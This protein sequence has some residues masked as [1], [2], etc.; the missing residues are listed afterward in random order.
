MPAAQ[1]PTL[2]L[3]VTATAITAVAIAAM[4][5]SDGPRRPLTFAGAVLLPGVE[6]SAASP[7]PDS[8]A[9]LVRPSAS[10]TRARTPAAPPAATPS[11]VA[12]SAGYSATMPV[13][14]PV[15]N[16]SS[17]A[18]PTAAPSSPQAGTPA[19]QPPRYAPATPTRPSGHPAKPNTGSSEA[20]LAQALF[21]A[22]N[23]ARQQAGLAPLSWSASLQRSAAGHN[24][25]MAQAGTLAFRVGD[26]P[27]LGVRQANQGVL[28]DYAAENIASTGTASLAA[29]LAAQ[30]LMLAEQPPN[31]SRRRNLLSTAVNAVGIDVLLDPAHDRMWIT[32]DFAHLSG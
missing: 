22:L 11:P 28:G 2:W 20:P 31:D 32:Q 10:P 19:S 6:H 21:A 12:S 26:E 27:A 1:A 3:S 23:D 5:T 7:A 18:A 15:G 4:A 16:S 9:P 17:T 24:R 14:V 8:S 25:Q 29:A 30:Q 13:V